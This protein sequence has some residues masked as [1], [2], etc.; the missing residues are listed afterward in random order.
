MNR[1]QKAIRYTKPLTEIDEKIDRL[2]EMMTTSGMY[3]VVAT[4]DGN[5]GSPPVFG[6][7]PLGDFSDLDN[8]TW[9]DQG[10]GSDTTPN[11]SQLTTTD[12][13][14]NEQGIFQM[15]D[16][17]YPSTAYCMAFGPSQAL[18]GKA[19]G[20]IGPTGFVFVFQ[21]N[22]SLGA[23]VEHTD[24]S[25]A[26]VDEYNA[27]TFTSQNIE[28]W[29]T[30][31]YQAGNI[32]LANDYAPAG[33][34]ENSDP[35]PTHG[36]Y[37]HTLLIPVRDD[38]TPIENEIK[39]TQ[40][41]P[42]RPRGVTSVVSR[43]D[44]GDPNYFPG[45]IKGFMGTLE[46]I[47]SNI[48][49]TFS[50]FA[51]SFTSDLAPITGAA[52]IV[53]GAAEYLSDAEQVISDAV[54]T[55]T[56][57]GDGL[58][59]LSGVQETLN[60][61]RA[62]GNIIPSDK[63]GERP[64]IA[65]GAKGSAEN[66]IQNNLS[67]TSTEVLID[68]AANYDGDGS[69]ESVVKHM[70]FV[71]QSGETL[72]LKGTINNINTEE[73]YAYTN[74]DDLILVDTYGFGPSQ[75]I[76]DKPVVKNVH[77]L[78]VGVVSVLGGDEQ[79]ASEQVQTFFD[80][81]VFGAAAA[82][83]SSGGQSIQLPGKDDPLVYFETVIPGGAKNLG[84]ISKPVKEET[85]FEKFKKKGENKK[86]VSK[87]DK[88]LMSLKL[89]PVPIKKVLLF[90][91][92]SSLKLMMMS[93]DKRAFKEKEIKM[94]SVNVYHD[95]YVDNQFPENVEQTSRVKK[96]L[97][98]N[99]ELSDPKTFKDPKPALTYGK[100]FGDDPKDKKVKEKDFSKKSA[101]RFFKTEK[102]VDTSRT[103]WLKG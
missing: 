15:P 54:E 18:S 59:L 55:F 27:G 96:I 66:P 13:D 95:A 14:G 61:A 41:V 92:K 38:G 52:E 79:E 100:V 81:T 93:P 22:N 26:F 98:R 4:D 53:T 57:V 20:Y 46:D 49:D 7:A 44:L 90:E 36:L 63:P 40:E 62:E 64:T 99:I 8:F 71:A 24:F 43:D 5:D 9:N 23:G 1:Y 89:L 85:L 35:P 56:G 51:N 67:D 31:M 72:G 32:K 58:N 78:V 87:M 101:G 70:S 10:D 12:A 48:A 3:T 33:T 2:N 19:L 74:G 60:I 76:L 102:K 91:V 80:Q 28:M 73:G 83:V 77:D 103:R 69:S 6:K 21:I 82:A 68:A 30:I 75:D 88:L 86:T 25:R 65:P 84:S 39:T 97:K 16:L 94:Q 45:F 42:A 29:R 34:D 11:I 37:T 17:N 50:E 47:G